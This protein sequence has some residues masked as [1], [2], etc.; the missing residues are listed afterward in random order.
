MI[1][2]HLNKLA[3]ATGTAL[4]RREKKPRQVPFAFAVAAARRSAASFRSSR[5]GKGSFGMWIPDRVD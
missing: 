1:E 5:V 2:M 4:R 3:P